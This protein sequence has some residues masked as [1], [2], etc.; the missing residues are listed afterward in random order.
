MPELSIIIPF[1]TS[2]EREF[3]KDRVID[4]AKNLQNDEKVE[5]IF[6]EGFSSFEYQELPQII[7]ENGHKYYKLNQSQFSQGEC[8]NFGAI[9]ATS[10]CIMPLDVDYHLSSENLQRL[11]KLI[12]IKNIAKNPNALICLPIV[13][14][15]K[16]GG[17]EILAYDTALWDTLVRE[18]LISGRREW[19]DFFSLV[20]SS[21][22][23]NKHKFLSIG[24]NDSAFVGH[25][26]EDHD[27]FMRLLC[28]TTHF[29]KMPKILEYD[30]SW[31]FFR[32][33]G[34][35]AWFSLFGNEASLHGI[36]LYHFWHIK[37]N[38]NGYLDRKKANHTLF[39]RH[40]RNRKTHS[41]KPLQTIEVVGQKVLLL[42]R[43]KGLLLESLR[44]VSV[45]LGEILHK[46][47]E[48]FF[49]GD[50]LKQEEFLEFLKTQKISQILFPNPYGND[51]RKAIYDFVRKINLPYLCFDRGA[52]PDSWF[53]DKNGFNADSAS[54]NEKHWNRP[55]NQEQIAQTKQYIANI[56]AVGEFLEPQGRIRGAFKLSKRLG[57]GD[58]RVVFV[59]LQVQSDSVILHFT[60]EPFSF[61]GFLEIVES[62][63][64]E[65]GGG[66]AFVAKKHPLSLGLDK[67]AYKHIIFAPDGTNLLDLLEICEC[68][69]TLNSGVGVYAMLAKKPCIV[70]GET[71]Y[72][73]N[74]LNL[75]AHDRESLVLALREVLQGQFVFDETK[76]LRFIHY[77]RSEFYSFGESFYKSGR[78]QGRKYRRVCRIDFYQIILRGEKFL[79]VPKY[80]KTY[81]GL[82]SLIYKPYLFEIY[83]NN[84]LLKTLNLLIPDFL[85][86][87]ISHT[88]FYRLLK[89]LLYN[90]KEFV[91]DSKNPLVKRFE[92]TF[93]N[94]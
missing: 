37:P 67:K 71:F 49:R 70:C 26:Y 40:L 61:D 44:E 82:K 94:P 64:E 31:N 65:F 54:Y 51:K 9:C 28:A 68:V 69:L 92:T 36:Y 18:D 76:C 74:G 72:H 27:F 62:L 5:V 33:K 22:V 80:Q 59:P 12:K 50:M 32:F 38:Q 77:L 6:V 63:A 60:H 73:F 88:K 79:E 35:R 15:N 89:K 41:I 39:Y 34:F 10:D 87:R 93:R 58:R 3:I 66:V 86:V 52:L 17:Q 46:S 42:C 13:F 85:L 7:Q 8:R 16:Q 43:H 78:G 84:F 56:L 20:S 47:E 1:G 4:K 48:E 45:Y 55:L 19:V 29:E 57:I 14:L 83:N 11:L 81:F 30:G 90:P 21:V 2:K 25:S 24:G 75:R 23:V 53:F 91:Q